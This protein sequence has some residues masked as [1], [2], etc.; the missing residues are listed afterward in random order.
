MA[1]LTSLLLATALVGGEPPAASSKAP[2]PGSIAD[3]GTSNGALRGGDLPPSG[4]LTPPRF[5]WTERRIIGAK[6]LSAGLVLGLI[7]GLAEW[8]AS[9]MTPSD[10]TQKAMLDNADR[11]HDRRVLGVAFL[12]AGSLAVISGAL[13]VAWPV[14]QDLAVSVSSAGLLMLSGRM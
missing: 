13:L 4:D 14:R 9:N 6:V 5:Q 3:S 12:G 7:G 11:V 1:I 10:N 8:S 2:I